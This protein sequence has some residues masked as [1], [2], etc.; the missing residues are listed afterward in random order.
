MAKQGFIDPKY[1]LPHYNTS[2]YRGYLSYLSKTIGEARTKEI[3]A[4][5][6]V[7]WE[8]LN[9][10]DNWVSEDFSEIFFDVLTSE[11]GLPEDFSFQAG[12]HALSPESMGTVP[13]LVSKML[14]T[15][16]FFNEAVR[17]ARKLNKIDHFE[18]QLSEA[19]KFYFSVKSNRITRH[20]KPIADNWSGNLEGVF[21]IHGVS[22]GGI[23]FSIVD[24]NT[25]EMKADWSH[26]N[27]SLLYISV[28]ALAVLVIILSFYFDFSQ[29]TKIGLVVAFNILLFFMMTQIKKDGRRRIADE[30]KFVENIVEEHE[31][32]YLELYES[33]AKLDRRFK[34]ANLLRSVLGRMI[35]SNTSEGLVQQTLSEIKSSLGYD[36]VMFFKHDPDQVRLVISAQAGFNS[37]VF[38]EISSYTLDLR[39]QTASGLHLGNLFR[40]KK[41]ILVPVSSDY[42][43]SLSEEG[44]R[45][46]LTSKSKSFLVCSV[47]LDHESFGMLLVDYTRDDIV[48]TQDDLHII[49][50]LANQLAILLDNARVLE[51]ETKLRKSFQ[52]FVPSTVIS[53]M[54]KSDDSIDTH[55]ARSAEVTVLFSDIRGFTTRSDSVPADILVRALNL[56]FTAMTE[57]VYRHGGIVDKFLGD[58]MMVLFNA[59]GTDAK[60]AESA[61]AAAIEMHRV[62]AQVNE[63]IESMMQDHGVWQPFDVGVGIH[64][65]PAVVGNIGSNQKTEFTAIGRTVNIAARLQDL[66]K[67]HPGIVIS[68]DVKIRLNSPFELIDLGLCQIRGIRGPMH[69]YSVP[70][71]CAMEVLALAKSS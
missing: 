19:G 63:S 3:V 40:Q 26:S 49:Q 54:M 42:I 71:S 38:N 70:S 62:L 27:S 16:A 52:K 21:K 24:D 6:P 44:R 69:V 34:E 51:Q 31:K 66:T 18:I 23:R 13:H 15:Q 48:V 22:N 33:K 35:Q 17:H 8:Y 67:M 37:D 30:A 2:I 68:D 28:S 55:F 46:I 60:H 9:T 58:G 32:R 64:T 11:K 36:R 10:N 39:E 20:L 53:Q 1:L 57:V 7:P 61:V 25:I 47:A 56:Y 50:N 45:L 4:K 43:N 12:L 29:S 14:S 65:G 41:S 59:F 5:M